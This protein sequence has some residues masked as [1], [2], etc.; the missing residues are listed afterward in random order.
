[1]PEVS[2]EEAIYLKYMCHLASLSYESDLDAMG[3]YI[4]KNKLSATDLKLFEV[5]STR[6]VL[7]NATIPHPSGPMKVAV[8]SFRG[9]STSEDML[10]GLEAAFYSDFLDSNGIIL[11]VGAD[12]F[13]SAYDKIRKTS[14]I[15]E[16]I[17]RA[18]TS[19]LVITGHSLGGALAT[20]CAADIHSISPSSDSFQIKIVTF[21]APRSLSSN[22]TKRIEE[23][24]L[25][26][27]RCVNYGDPVPMLRFATMGFGHVGEPSE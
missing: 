16:T 19:G 15:A 18:K 11:G 13:V 12:G 9:T 24:K 4:F 26:H 7:F 3:M 22:T 5:D 2:S 8:V 1:M 6:A 20:L 27:Y 17:T 14:L 21:G 10:I 25:E 23:M